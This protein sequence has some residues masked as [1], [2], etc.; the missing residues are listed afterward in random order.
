MCLWTYVSQMLVCPTFSKIS[1]ISALCIE[2][3]VENVGRNILCAS[4]C[5]KSWFFQL[6]SRNAPKSWFSNFSK[7]FHE[8]SHYAWRNW[9]KKL[10]NQLFEALGSKNVGFPIFS[11]KSAIHSA[12]IRLKFGK[13]WNLSVSIH[14]NTN[15]YMNILA[16]EIVITL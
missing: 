15:T 16:E 10:E 13:S 6:C 12:E 14:R 7:T 1:G 8:F 11:A 3:F 9:L 2:D 4:R 5:F